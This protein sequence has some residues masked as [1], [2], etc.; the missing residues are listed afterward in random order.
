MTPP[1]STL[2]QRESATAQQDAKLELHRL[3]REVEMTMTADRLPSPSTKP[4]YHPRLRDEPVSA[5]PSVPLARSLPDALLRLQRLAGNAA[6]AARLAT[7]QNSGA[8][9]RTVPAEGPIE[10]VG[11]DPPQ[12]VGI[13][14][15]DRQNE[16][17]QVQ[18]TIGDGH[19]LTNTRFVGDVVLEGCFDNERTVRFGSDGP[20][21]TKL[22][23][24][25]VDIGLSLP[26]FGV[27]G[28]FRAETKSRIQVFQRSAG[29]KDDG[30]VGPI[31]MGEFDRR[32]PGGGGG[33]TPPPVVAPTVTTATA[34][35]APNGGP[36]TRLTVG[37]GEFVDLTASAAVAWTAAG[38]TL[39]LPSG[40]A[41]RWTAPE[42][43]S[44]AVTATPAGGPPTVTTFQVVPP[45]SISMTRAVVNPIPAGQAGADMLT[46]V[47]FGHTEVSFSRVQWLED[48][49]PPSGVHGYFLLGKGAAMD[50]NHHPNPA[51]V[52]L[53]PDNHFLHDHCGS[54]FPLSP[55]FQRI[56]PLPPFFG[57]G[58]FWSIPNRFKIVGAA[59]AGTPF[60]T[61]TQLFTVDTSGTTTVSKQGASI[62]RTSA[63][64]V[65]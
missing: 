43:G 55:P 15:T 13:P 61:S 53:R 4:P 10:M 29:V 31:T 64:A 38:G 18:R 36:N 56:L 20:A 8:T 35:A 12:P 40:N 11:S 7:A 60:F 26:K 63:G 54:G 50:L 49:G 9:G 59:G 37:P 51:F 58:W 27:D 47:D 14:T 41:T 21:V 16:P 62:T 42:T 39:S 17:S 65:T 52:T 46:D 5:P 33:P 45:D 6:V 34:A 30:I 3:P 22:Q 28:K 2:P 25:M 48:P 44:I 1:P 57:G 23:Q 19:D 32:I 24:A